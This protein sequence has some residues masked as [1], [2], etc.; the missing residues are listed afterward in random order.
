MPR[1][2]TSSMPCGLFV[3]KPFG[4]HSMEKPSW[5]IVRIFPPGTASASSSR[6]SASFPASE[7]DFTR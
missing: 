6:I 2:F 4:P 5:R 1:S 3:R 7:R